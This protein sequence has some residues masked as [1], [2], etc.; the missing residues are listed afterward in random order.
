MGEN[1]REGE[2][3]GGELNKSN[4]KIIPRLCKC[5][6]DSAIPGLMFTPCECVLLEVVSNAHL[7][8]WW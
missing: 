2:R 1:L 6:C 7:K 8:T 3:K 5:P 4:K